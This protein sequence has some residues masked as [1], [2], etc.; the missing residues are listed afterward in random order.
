MNVDALL[1]HYGVVAIFLGAMAEG[2]TFVLAG[3]VLAHR[4]LVSPAEAALAA[5]LG[6]ASADQLCFFL[7]RRARGSRLVE[8]A[9]ATPAFARALRFIE[10]YPTAYI[11]AFRYLY[12]LRV[13]S[14]VALGVSNV[15]AG[16]FI[17]LNLVS[18]AVWA[19]VF[20][21]IGYV[22][23]HAVDGLLARFH[24]QHPAL[25]ILALLGGIVGGLSWWHARAARLRA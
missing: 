17:A 22:F 11:L 16:R 9:R 3:G 20:T 1:A 12:G 15:S 24:L 4:G 7:G 19:M 2:E 10:L 5:F 6:S 18:A 13:V 21:G 14:P 8:R 23:G 25:I